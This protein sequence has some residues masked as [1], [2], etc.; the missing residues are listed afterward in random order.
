MG[1]LGFGLAVLGGIAAIVGL[2]LLVAWRSPGDVAQILDWK[3]TRSPELEAQNEA[4]D[5]SQML[6]AQNARRRRRG[7]PDRTLEQVELEV[8]RDQAWRREQCERLLGG[9]SPAEAAEDEADLL[10]AV[11]ARRARH[12]RPPLTASE[13]RER[14]AL[15]AETPRPPRAAR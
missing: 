7:Q 4:D 14:L 11:N 2:S 9:E 8:A 10:R 13:Y 3:P 1:D 5:V 12:G 15:R 6:A